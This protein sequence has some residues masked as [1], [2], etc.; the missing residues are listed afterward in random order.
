M[1]LTAFPNGISS[2]GVPVLGGTNDVMAFGKVYFVAKG[3]SDDNNGLDINRP[4]L[5]VQKALN[6]VGDF[7][8]IFVMPGSYDEQL[9]TGQNPGSMGS[10][11][12]STDGQGRYVSL[13]G[14][15]PTL[16]PFDNPQLYNVSGSTATIRMRA[17]GWRVSGFRIVGDTGS[18][19]CMTLEFDQAGATADTD[20][21]PG[22]TVDHCVFY[23]AVDN[24]SG[25]DFQNAPP[26]IR[27]LNNIF[28]LF[29]TGF[30]CIR[31]SVSSVAQANRCSILGNQFID[32]V[33]AID[34]NPRGFN[35]SIIMDNVINDGHVNTL[36]TGL[37]NTGGNDCEVHRN[38]LSGDYTTD[39]GRYVAGSGD[40]WSG[41]YT[42]DTG[43]AS[44]SVDGSGL[45]VKI[46]QAG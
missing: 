36:I 27:V 4:F 39:L 21:A 44:T 13:V 6:T 34:M 16:I 7:G 29:E 18:P 22:T 14:V 23:G 10:V 40:D 28:E 35:A 20:W 12:T 24:C 33:N 42:M 1:G 11:P 25:I 32:N 8:T 26:D 19:L 45:T 31:S 41:N 30:A 15:R 38:Y 46:P 2:M 3:G 5:T 43:A 37:D 17:A 9:A